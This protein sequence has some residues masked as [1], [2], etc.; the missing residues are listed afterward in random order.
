M[1][2]CISHT[3]AVEWLLSRQDPVA[4]G[5]AK[6]YPAGTGA[7]ACP[8]TA[9]ALLRAC[10]ALSIRPSPARP[11]DVLVSASNA[12][13]HCPNT[14][15]HLQQSAQGNGMFLSLGRGVG[16]CAPP[17]AFAQA[18]TQLDDQGAIALAYALC[19]RFSPQ[20]RGWCERAGRRALCPPAHLERCAAAV[21][22][23]GSRRAQRAA[24]LVAGGAR[25][26]LAMGLAMLFSLPPRFGGYGL[27]QARFAAELTLPLS[28]GATEPAR[29][30]SCV[31]DVLIAREDRGQPAR[32]VLIDCAEA[33]LPV[34]R[35][36]PRCAGAT[37]WEHALL[38]RQATYV[39]VRAEQL[40]SFDAVEAQAERMRRTLGKLKPRL[41][42]ELARRYRRRRMALWKRF[43]V[44]ALAP[45]AETYGLAT[46]LPARA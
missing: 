8:P 18:C 44:P 38:P 24:S 3:T 26:P 35:A 19:S 25:T 27:G 41:S 45:S 20:R 40:K 31:P 43:V 15:V 21:C 32:L 36:G 4:S 9:A 37:A 6:P 33:G 7:P 10:N 11:L 46:L 12:R 5:W 34:A 13:R 17:L 30:A 2:I 39:R 29:Y 14:L 22:A 28:G 16:L 23:P 42:P 1:D